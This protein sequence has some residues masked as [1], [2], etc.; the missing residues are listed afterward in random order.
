MDSTAHYDSPL[1]GIT[2]AS[3]GNALVG[4]WFDGQKYFASVLQ[5]NAEEK[6]LPVFDEAA[7]WLD[8]YFSGSEPDF[9]PP[10]LL[11]GTPF[12]R[13]VWGALMAVPF[14]Q[15]VTYGWLACRLGL[16][17]AAARAV[18]GAVARNPVSLIVPCH[19]VIG[20][21][22]R[23]TGYAGGEWRKAWLTGLEKQSKV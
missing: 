6:A 11:R 1:G 5:E 3:D 8:A 22:G 19:R 2:L 13:A 9:T 10:L 20:A 23:L 7:R 18:G 14:G 12:R 4:L 15:T 16:P 21:D 17:A